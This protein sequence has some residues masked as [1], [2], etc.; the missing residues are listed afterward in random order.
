MDIIPTSDDTT[1]QV[2]AAEQ[3]NTEVQQTQQNGIQKRIDELTAKSY[4]KDAQILKLTDLLQQ[5]VM[6]QA[7]K[8]QPQQTPAN[9]FDGV[10]Y[11][12]ANSVTTAFQNALRLQEQKFAAQLAQVQ[13]QAAGGEVMNEATQRGINDPRITIRA[14]QLAQSWKQQGLPFVAGDAITFALGEAAAGALPGGPVV[15]QPNGRFA[16]ANSTLT[17][18]NPPPPSAVPQRQKELPPNFDSLDTDKQIAMLEA[19]LGDKAW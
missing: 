4:E 13:V 14:Q 18:P 8:A 9:P 7:Q 11:S 12:D 3:P 19:R 16:P 5:Q 17:S 1:A 6:A 2:P 10:D 15:R